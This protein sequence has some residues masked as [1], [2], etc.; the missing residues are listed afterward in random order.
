MERDRISGDVVPLPHQLPVKISTPPVS[1]VDIPM[2]LQ[3]IQAQNEDLLA[4]LG[5]QLRRNHDLECRLR[6][7]Q[8][9]AEKTQATLLSKEDEVLLLTEKL[10]RHEGREIQLTEELHRLRVQVGEM[11][12]K[13]EAYDQSLQ[14]TMRAEEAQRELTQELH[15]QFQLIAEL[16]S[17]LESERSET[18]QALAAAADFSRQLEEASNRYRE[19]LAC[20]VSNHERTI[21]LLESQARTSKDSF[22][23]LDQKHQALL[24]ELRDYT[25][26]IIV[27]ENR[28][29][30]AERRREEIENKYQSEVETLQNQLVQT[31]ADC[32]S[33]L[34]E[35]KVLQESLGETESRLSKSETENIKLRNQ[36][37]ALTLI[38][39]QAARDRGQLEDRIKGA[40]TINSHLSD[41]IAELRKE[42]S[43]LQFNKSPSLEQNSHAD[44]KTKDISEVLVSER[45]DL[46][47]IF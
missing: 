19:D 17:Q 15:Q 12:A 24:T 41:T 39:E 3:V 7:L 14:K 33:A 25:E 10:S 28:C 35:L 46:G 47:E 45:G 8:Q 40:Q 21:G 9:S 5:I 11:T 36:L 27:L 26:K 34:V 32:A 43:R 20:N 31:K 23:R 1:A 42:N 30:L 13:T 29:V 37:N 22:I 18:K 44:V 6:S 2:A 4:R 16:Q 38:Y